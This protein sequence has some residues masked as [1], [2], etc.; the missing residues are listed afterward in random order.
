M[1]MQRITNVPDYLTD[2]GKEIYRSIA[3]DLRDRGILHQADVPHIAAYASTM[4]RFE[5]IQSQLL[6]SKIGIEDPN[7]KPIINPK[8]KASNQLLVVLNATAQ[9]LGLTPYG[10]GISKRETKPDEE[11]ESGLTALLGG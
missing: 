6:D 9:K 2:R 3:A 11:K 8:V 5:E 4:A 10:R 7:G 1:R